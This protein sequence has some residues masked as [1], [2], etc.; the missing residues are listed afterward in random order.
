M[1]TLEQ[2]PTSQMLTSLASG[3]CPSCGE[4]KNAR[5][6]F[7]LRCYKQLSISTQRSLYRRVGHGYEQAVLKAM[8]YLFCNQ[9]HLPAEGTR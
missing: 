7:C 6:T 3:V 2:F 8:D 1:I 4:R 5:Q 9:V